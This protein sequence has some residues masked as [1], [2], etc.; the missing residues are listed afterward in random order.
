MRGP[1]D[2]LE[3]LRNNVF[4]DNIPYHIWLGG[5]YLAYKYIPKNY[6]GA[7]NLD[8]INSQILDFFEN[9]SLYV[10]QLNGIL[11]QP[12]DSCHG[13]VWKVE[14]NDQNPQN[15]PM[16]IGNGPAKFS[17][18]FNRPM[19]TS[20]NPFLTF[21]VRFPFTQNAVLDSSYWSADHKVWTAYKTID[22]STGD[23]QNT[24]RVAYA[25]DLDHFE[26]PIERSRFNFV[27]QAASSQSVDFIATPGIGKVHLEW[28]LSDSTNVLGYNLYR[29]TMPTPST[30]SDTLL[31]NNSLLTD[32]LYNDFAVTPGMTYYYLF[33]VVR[34]D[35]SESDYSKV[36][37]ATPL[38]AANG[39]AN[40]DGL[41]NVLDVTSVISYMLNQN[42][43]PFMYDAADVNN[44]NAIDILDVIGII[45]IIHGKKKAGNILAGTNPDPAYIWLDSASIN[46][47]STG[48]V[49]AL[50]FE[51]SGKNLSELELICRQQGFE[52]AHGIV[53][54]KL[55]GILY[56]TRNQAIREGMVDLFCILKP[57]STMSWGEVRAGDADGNRVIVQKGVKGLAAASE[58]NLQASPNPFSSNLTLSY[59]LNEPATVNLAV[60]D[61]NGKLV[62]T[63]EN[64][65]EPA[66]IHKIEW[67]GKSGDNAALPSGIY[68]VRL[69]GETSSGN[70]IKSEVKIILNK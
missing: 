70:K 43:Q 25:K 35:F 40:G 54:G 26:I 29:F 23:G 65:Q 14:I 31:I 4:I 9:P 6:W 68:M 2:T 51:L 13:V 24:I 22:M 8:V 10:V 27:I 53:N 52:F 66:G 69:S 1:S 42:P 19:D 5:D 48:Q 49:A 58:T 30:F 16:V 56:N 11:N 3:A 12:P 59:S 44:D 47:Q 21:G 62:S 41:V 63:I 7:T 46:F 28:P 15:V 36:V 38:T 55:L 39:D 37:F 50:Q 64:K 34:T 32:S 17:V 18:F 20:F 67:N 33:T 61:L 60:Y 57:C 45:N